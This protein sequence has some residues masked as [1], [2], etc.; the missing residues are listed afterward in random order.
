ME[1]IKI[2]FLPRF[3]SAEILADKFSNYFMRKTTIIK[4]KIISDTPNTICNISMNAVVMFNGKMVELLRPT[5]E[6]E[7]KEIIIKSP[8]KS[9]DLNP[10]PTGLMKKCVDH[11][12]PLITAVINRSMDESVMPLCLKRATITPLLKRSGFNKEDMKNYCPISN[13][14]F[15]SKL[16]EKLVARRIEELLEHNDINEIY[17]SAYCRGHSTDTDLLKMNSSIDVALHEGS[18]TALIMLD[19]SAAF[20]STEAFRILLWNQGKGLNS[21]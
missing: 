14:P 2:N 6:V 4:N 7:V 10:L 9:C 20:N 3:T 16:I 15:I 19:L 17:Q 12:L 5:S 18:I 13:L 8:N 11:F 1:N 21:T